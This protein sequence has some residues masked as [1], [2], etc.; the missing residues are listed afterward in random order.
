MN[1]ISPGPVNTLAARGIPGFVEMK[2]RAVERA[3]L[4][5]TATPEEVGALA[6]FLASDSAVSMTGQVILMDGGLS[7]I[8]P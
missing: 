7:L 8:A 1:C 4:Q 2:T 5:R 6:T 3:P